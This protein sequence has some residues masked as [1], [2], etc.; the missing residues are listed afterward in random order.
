MRRSKRPAGFKC[1]FGVLRE[2]CK[3]FIYKT[4]Y[5]ILGVL[6]KEEEDDGRFF[7]LIK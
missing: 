6:G 3:T 2:D 1:E 5:E 7:I 4:L